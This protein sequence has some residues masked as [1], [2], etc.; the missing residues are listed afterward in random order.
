MSEEIDELRTGGIRR[1]LVALAMVAAMAVGLSWALASRDRGEPELA[2]RV[3]IVGGTPTDLVEVIGEAGFE[4]TQ[5]SWLEAQTQC[6]DEQG[7][8]DVAAVV[9]HADEHGY[10]FVALMLGDDM[11]FEPTILGEAAPEHAMAAVI[12]VGDLAA[13]GSRVLW[14]APPDQLDYAPG[15]RR[16]EALRMALYE[17]PDLL[18]LWVDPTR[19]QR[20]QQVQL[21]D[22]VEARTLLGRAL[23]RY[24][25]ARSLWQQ[26]G[27]AQSDA[28]L[29]RGGRL[30]RETPL[31][32]RVDEQRKVALQHAAPRLRFVDERG[33]STATTI[34]PTDDWVVTP[35]G[36]VGLRRVAGGWQRWRFD[37]ELPVLDGEIGLSMRHPVVSIGGSLLG[38]EGSGMTWSTALGQRGE[39]TTIS[40]L[41]PG[42]LYDPG[43]VIPAWLDDEVAVLARLSVDDQL[44]LGF[45]GLGIPD[46]PKLATVPLA[47]LHPMADATRLTIE[48]LHPSTA[49]LYVVVSDISETYELRF[50][51]IRV[52]LDPAG[53]RAGMIAIAGDPP[54]LDYAVSGAVRTLAQLGE[55]TRAVDLGLLPNFVSG[56]LVVAPDGTWL[57]WR[58]PGEAGAIWALAIVGDTLATPV[59]VGESLSDPQISADSQT[60]LLTVERELPELG[61]FHYS[62]LVP[63]PSP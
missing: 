42:A 18:A 4:A 43:Y 38:F 2:H 62:S 36:A 19:D 14:G 15:V 48:S 6:A 1:I 32:L 26:K 37:R 39:L 24:R 7:G 58:L 47:E 33:E 30:V 40:R 41:K 5:I 45:V 55:R 53:L 57:A 51:L 11:P 52:E 12:G 54:M 13:E 23:A 31:S 9:D 22:L 44:W 27:G 21:G 35:G 34:D 17:H 29:V 49:G 16:S 25:G 20:A 10:G 8:L 63:R 61:A 28:M 56:S 60:L 59:R 46:G 50:Q 3:L